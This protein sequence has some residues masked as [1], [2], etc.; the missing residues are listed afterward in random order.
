LLPEGALY[1]GYRHSLEKFAGTVFG[2]AAVTPA[3]ILDDF[4]VAP[5]TLDR[6]SGEFDVRYGVTDWI[7]AEVSVPVTKNEMINLTDL[8]A[9]QTSTQFI[10]DVAI[11]GLVDLLNMEEYRLSATLGATLPT[12]KIGKKGTRSNGLRGV[13]PY[14]MQGG[15]RSFDILAGGTFQAQNEASSIGAQVNTVMRVHSNS[16][17]YRLGDEFSLS[18]W[19]AYNI[20]EWMSFSIRGLFERQ[21]DISGFDTRVDAVNNPLGSPLAQGGDRFFIP[22][23]V[24]LYLRE[25]RAA[26]H[27]L[28]LELYYPAHENMTGTQMSVDRKLVISWQSVF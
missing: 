17:G 16:K 2:D 20:S 14:T 18:V 27:R 7:T 9:Y 1:A 12:G 10:G 8:G 5:L 19:G 25:G 13:L 22:F 24:N 23:G 28:S 21:G 11:R 26:G 15:S 6:V 4:A 3:A